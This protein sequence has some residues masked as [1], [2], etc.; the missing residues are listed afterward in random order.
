V[1]LLLPIATAF[2]AAAAPAATIRVVAWR[3]AGVPE[4]SATSL[5]RACE[6]AL[7]ELTSL[8]L[9]PSLHSSPL[10]RRCGADDH[11]CWTQL[12][13]R[14]GADY[15]LAL[16]AEPAGGLTV[17]LMLVDLRAGHVVAQRRFT[18]PSP[19]AASQGA[20][21]AVDALMP[22]FLHRGYGGVLVEMPGG[23]RLKVD[24]KVVLS[25]PSRGPVAV[26]SGH[27]EVDLLLPDGTAVLARADVA[28]GQIAALAL[29]ARPP[30]SGERRSNDALRVTSA[31]L[32][33]AGT[34]AVV[35]SLALG[36]VVNLRTGNLNPCTPPSHDCSTR[37]EAEAEHQ[38]L[39]QYAQTANLL[40]YG[41]GALAVGGGLVFTFDLVQGGGK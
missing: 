13:G 27:H 24:G 41:G 33:A 14:T 30:A 28:E 11:G 32:W 4:A 8:S 5:T 16:V 40:L 35:T 21:A 6:A 9:Q 37:E 29:G 2:W 1:R 20:R 36:T 12:A 34:V 31:A 15:G 38:A 23:S 39:A 7:R 19:D 18:G 25:Q 10:S 3:A 22:P 17:D 26:S